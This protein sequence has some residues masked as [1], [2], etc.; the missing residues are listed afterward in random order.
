MLDVIFIHSPSSSY[1]SN[2]IASSVVNIVLTIAGIILHSFVLFIFWTS[3]K[4][5]SKLS[6]FAIMLLCSIDFGVGTV[7]NPLFAFRKV[8]HNVWLIEMSVLCGLWHSNI[9]LLW[10]FGR[11][12]FHLFIKIE[13]Y[14]A[15]IHPILHRIHFTK[16][17]FLLTWIFFW[18]LVIA[19]IV[20]CVY[21][22]FLAVL[23]SV[24]LVVLTCF[25]TYVAIYVVA[26]KKMLEK[27]HNNSYQESRRNLI[28]FHENWRWK[29]VTFW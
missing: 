11:Y 24:I 29:K 18:F 21:F 17:M 25:F 4:M 7:V 12:Y 19:W 10:D 9:L 28:I 8:Y 6:S 16:R 14:F 3:R 26:R 20:C 22:T 23:I 5:G 2:A 1:I 13:R 15:R 27:V